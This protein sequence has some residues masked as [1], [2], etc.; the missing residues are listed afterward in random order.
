L[1]NHPIEMTMHEIRMAVAAW[2]GTQMDWAGLMF[3]HL[4]RETIKAMEDLVVNPAKCAITFLFEQVVKL[5]LTN[6]QLTMLEPDEPSQKKRQ[7]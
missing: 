5:K 3:Y 2:N 6:L 4:L 1:E 7:Q